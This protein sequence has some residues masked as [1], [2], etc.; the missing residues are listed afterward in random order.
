VLSK[1]RVCEG[2]STCCSTM[3]TLF[4]L[5]VLLRGLPRPRGVLIG[6]VSPLGG[7]PVVGVW[8]F[9]VTVCKFE[10]GVERSPPLPF[11]EDVGVAVG[12]LGV[13]VVVLVLF[14]NLG[15][16][17]VKRQVSLF[18]FLLLLLLLLLRLFSG[19][20]FLLL[21]APEFCTVVDE[22]DGG[23]LVDEVGVVVVTLLLLVVGD[24]KCDFFLEEEGDGVWGFDGGGV[25]IAEMV[26]RFVGDLLLWDLLDLRVEVAGWGVEKVDPG[27]WVI[28][29]IVRSLREGEPDDVED[30]IISATFSEMLEAL[31]V[32]LSRADDEFMELYGDFEE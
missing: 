22:E 12:G 4:L 25:E 31:E 16:R 11:V 9:E 3:S 27:G 5:L 2:S 20:D 17:D 13:V 26:S 19:D 10:E 1:I 32:D 18:F 24:C 23:F 21:V 15:L 7:G 28:G 29:W 6:G 8:C 30:F 14:R